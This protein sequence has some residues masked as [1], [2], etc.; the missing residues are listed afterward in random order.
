MRRSLVLLAVLLCVA[1]SWPATPQA[2]RGPTVSADLRGPRA[3]GERIRVII[4]GSQPALGSVRG[5]LRG[6]L[7][8]ELTHGGAIAVDVTPEEFDRLS[9]DPSISHL[10]GDVPVAADMAV[11]NRITGASSVWQ[12]TSGLLGLTGTPGANGERDRR[13]GRRLGHRRA[14]G[15]RQPRRRTRELRVVGA[16]HRLATHSATARTSPARLAGS[17]T[18]ASRVT[19]AYG[20][21]SAPA[22]RLIDVRVLGSNGMGLTSDVIAGIDWAVANRAR[23]GIRVINLALGH[24]VT[25]PSTIDPL[26]QGSRARRCRGHRCRRVGR[27]LR[28]HQHGRSGAGRHHLA[29]QL[30]LCHHGRRN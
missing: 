15:A 19:S 8:R 25:E 22:V 9:K 16:G 5:R 18:A 21:G 2:Q 26:C 17:T 29:G 10:S 4:Q 1:G 24:P 13:G 30:S 27:Q 6:L 7:R 11:T 28:T 20:G 14:H 3:R 23:Y 12:G